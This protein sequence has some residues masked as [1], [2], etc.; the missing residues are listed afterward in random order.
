M[1]RQHTRSRL[2]HARGTVNQTH[3]SPIWQ[4]AKEAG[5]EYLRECITATCART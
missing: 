1:K 3:Y 4:D 2:V 5:P